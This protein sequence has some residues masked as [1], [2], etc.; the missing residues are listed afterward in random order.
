MPKEEM[1]NTTSEAKSFDVVRTI[2][3]HLPGKV[4]NAGRNPGK[5]GDFSGSTPGTKA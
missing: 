1:I 4:G 5:P 3:P 2:D